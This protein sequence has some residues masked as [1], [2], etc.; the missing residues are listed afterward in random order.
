MVDFF[1]SESNQVVVPAIISSLTVLDD[2]PV[3][4]SG[5]S[6]C[7]SKV[8]N[9]MVLEVAY[10]MQIDNEVLLLPNATIFSY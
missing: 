3:D 5:G 2:T 8:T 1:L 9:T 4:G 6:A 10:A 7:P